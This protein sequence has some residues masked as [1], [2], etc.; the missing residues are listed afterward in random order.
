MVI[1]VYSKPAC[2][3]C[4][5]SKKLL[6]KHGL[7][8]TEYDVI[9]NVEAYDFVVNVLGYRAAPVIVVRNSEGEIEKSWAGFN[10]ENIEN[11]A[12]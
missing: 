5:Q 6:E 1:E 4:V 12:E 8:F 9:E 2:V 3:Q 10:P 11:I 7:T